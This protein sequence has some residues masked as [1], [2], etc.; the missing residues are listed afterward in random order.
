MTGI[1]WLWRPSDDVSG[2]ST[3]EMFRKE[4]PKPVEIKKGSA[5][6]HRHP[7]RQQRQRA[8]RPMRSGRN[9]PNTGPELLPTVAGRMRAR[10]Q[11]LQ[12]KKKNLLNEI[13]PRPFSFPPTPPVQCL[14]F[15]RI[16]SRVPDPQPEPHH[17]KPEPELGFQNYFV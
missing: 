9:Q 6:T 3:A 11:P 13:G 7:S 15:F 17:F 12:T 10:R 1:G 2:T 5:S 4:E 14:F 8:K 16:L